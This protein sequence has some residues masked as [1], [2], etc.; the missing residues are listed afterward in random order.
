MPPHTDTSFVVGRYVESL[1]EI[2]AGKTYILITQSEGI[3][4]KRL[5]KRTE[6]AVT[7]SSD[8]M[9]YAPYDIKLS[10]I[11]QIWEFACSFNM[12]EA[13]PDDL[14]NINVKDALISVRREIQDVRQQL[15]L[16][17]KR[18]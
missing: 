6:D 10:D 9:V 14:A 2:R 18:N 17:S 5:K 3:I 16:K 15:G 1:G 7:V 11:A 12:K 8:N 13:D 4:Y